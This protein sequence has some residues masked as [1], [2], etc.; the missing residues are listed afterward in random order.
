[1]FSRKLPATAT[2]HPI[3]A[4]LDALAR[5]S[6]LITRRSL[7][8]S[9]QGFLLS[10]LQCATRGSSSLNHI[11]M[12]LGSFEAAAMSRQALHKRFSPES[13]DFLTSVIGALIAHRNKRQLRT[14]G[15]GPFERILIEDSTVIPMAKSNATQFPNNGNCKGATAGCKVNLLTDL[16]HGSVLASRLHQARQPDQALALD[17]LDHC[18]ARDLVIR[19]MGFFTLKALRGIEARKALWISRLPASISLSDLHGVR[20][21]ELLKRTKLEQ[22]DLPVVIGSQRWNQQPHRARLVATRLT[23]QQAEKNRRHRRRQA[24]KHGATPSKSGL[25]RDGWRLIVTNLDNSE[26]DVNRLN[27]LYALRWSI[28]IQFRA[29]KQACRIGLSLNHKT[30][31]YH[32]EALVLAAMIF[33]LLSLREHAQIRTQFPPGNL[34][35]LEKLTDAYANYLL[36]LNR[37]NLS[38]PFYPDPRHLYHDRRTRSTLWESIYYCLG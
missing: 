2:P 23:S 26:F 7:K 10:L 32:I 17:I 31:P 4:D 6:G 33:Q 30:D 25:L 8:F 22:L 36:T 27:A 20:I 21:E 3:F 18:K 15:I 16:L 11:A 12:A 19:D 38:T 13:S 28:E 37:A 34:P 9:A 29:L 24:K 35:S 1:M 14:L 5:Q